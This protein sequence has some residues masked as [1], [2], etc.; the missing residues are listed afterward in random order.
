MGKIIF[1]LVLLVASITI[2]FGAH[3]I[4]SGSKVEAHPDVLAANAG[5]DQTV[6]GPSPVMVQF[7]GSRSQPSSGCVEIDSYKWYNQWG[8]LRAEGVAPIFE[9]NF[10][11]QDPKPGTSRT[12]TLVVEDCA[13]EP[14]H[15][16]VSHEDDVTITLGE[17][18]SLSASAGADITVPGPSSV[19][20]WFDGDSNVI[21][22]TCKWYNQWGTFRSDL[23]DTLIEVNFGNN[24]PKPGTTRSFRLVVEDSEG[25]AAEDWV[26]ITLGESEPVVANAGP[27]QTVPGPNPV[28]VEFSGV[29]STGPIVRYQWFNQRG[30]LRAEEE[31]PVFEVNF[32][33]N[34][35]PSGTTD[36]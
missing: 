9:V 24:N 33:N 7:D 19:E 21:D 36:P 4:P 2:G 17:T 25:N 27:A 14:P 34:D 16:G 31:S 32:G 10:G 22:Y 30:L 20:V 28:L 15:H 6:A 29:R 8:T 18:E 3:I 1:G 35:P 13:D 5:P 26:V 23:C 11:H 12:F